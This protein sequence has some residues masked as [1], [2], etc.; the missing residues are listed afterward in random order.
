MSKKKD[1]R[2]IIISGAPRI[3]RSCCAVV[4]GGTVCRRRAWGVPGELYVHRQP[5][6]VWTPL[7]CRTHIA[8]AEKYGTVIVSYGDFLRLSDG[9]VVPRVP[10]DR[11]REF[12][13]E[14]RG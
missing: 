5:G 11:L 10:V 3:H 7:L 12:L 13:A 6:L 4:A 8:M 9:R 1:S 2:L 14:R